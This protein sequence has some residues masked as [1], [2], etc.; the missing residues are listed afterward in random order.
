MTKARQPVVVITGASAGVGRA[1]VREFARR[2]ASRGGACIG[3]IARGHEG[4]EG[5]RRDVEKLGGRALALPLDVADSF[6]VEAAAERVERELGPIDVWVNCAMVSVFATVIQTTAEEF[7]RV[8]EVTYLGYVHGTL[9]AL[10][11]MKPRDRGVIV[12]VGS[13]LAHRSI[14]LQA[15]YCAA[16]HAMQ[17][18]TES[19]RVELLHDRSHVGLTVVQMPALNTPQFEWSRAKL[20][21]QP[22][23]VP[24]I[25]QPE[26]AARAIFHAARHPRK[27]YAV[28]GSTLVAIMAE[29]LAPGL[30]D[31][32]L[33]HNGYRSQ[34]TREPISP[35][36]QDNLFAPVEGDFG[37]H[38]RF[39]RRA[40]AH[41]IEAWGARNRAWL[42]LGAIGAAAVA[43]YAAGSGAPR[44]RREGDGAPGPAPTGPMGQVTELSALRMRDPESSCGCISDGD[45]VS[46]DEMRGPDRAAVHSA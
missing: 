43:W 7:K 37:A 19:L 40:Q 1:A 34:M 35:D 6:A 36:R 41:S 39:D 8:T 28:G 33:A 20:A 16:K 22:Q 32:Y 14:P 17:G 26:V 3:L 15:A 42:A 21:R 2:Y 31:R 38:G 44:A 29:K 10:R 11:R 46:S 25:Y 13:A 12:Q 30:A 5:A 23:P 24:P 27:Q 45:A 9:A 4:L 18:F